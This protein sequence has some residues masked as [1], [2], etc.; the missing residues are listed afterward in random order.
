[1]S[2]LLNTKQFCIAVASHISN[3]SRIPYLIECLTSLTTQKVPVDVYLSISCVNDEVKEKTLNSINNENKILNEYLNIRFRKQKTSQMRH[4]FMLYQEIHQK[5]QWILFCDDD[6]TYHKDRTNYFMQTTRTTELQID[7]INETRDVTLPKLEL[8]GVYENISQPTHHTKRHEYWCYCIRMDL[9]TRFFNVVE[10]AI[11]VLDDRCC[12]VLFAEY[13]RRKSPNWIYATINEP[14]YYY[15][16][17]ENDDSITG[18]IQMN[19]HKYT[20]QTSPPPMDDDNWLSYVLKWNDYLKDNIHI[21]LHDTYLRT[22]VGSDLD[23]ILRTEFQNNYFI[24]DYVD[25]KHIMR[26]TDLHNRVKRVCAD[27]YDLGL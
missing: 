5:H 7:T 11:H 17:D 15:R 18:F 3:E 26:M 16:E 21:F 10:P 2:I 6:D 22:L 1:M 14:L 24:L 8:A 19:Q 9:L 13:L 4:Y 23:T 20:N 12:D 27:I 25:Q